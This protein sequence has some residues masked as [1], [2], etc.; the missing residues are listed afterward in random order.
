MRGRT[1][2]IVAVAVALVAA[3][4]TVIVN[5]GD[6]EAKSVKGL[7]NIEDVETKEKAKK[8]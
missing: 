6:G 5:Q 1:A 7:I 8:K 3:C 4:A 2:V